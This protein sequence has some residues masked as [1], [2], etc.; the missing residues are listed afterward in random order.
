MPF[1]SWRITL[2]LS[3]PQ[4]ASRYSSNLW[5]PCSFQP[6]WLSAGLTQSRGLHPRWRVL[7]M[8]C[9]RAQQVRTDTRHINVEGMMHEARSTGAL[10]CTKKL[11]RMTDMLVLS[12]HLLPSTII[13]FLYQSMVSELI[14]IW[15]PVHW[16]RFVVVV[17]RLRK[18]AAQSP[19]PAPDVLAR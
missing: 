8:E 2:K 9:L 18:A 15:G 16:F 7:K 19:P 4:E 14:S 6:R 10:C 13:N 12:I 1:D 17:T 5:P 3:A 11:A